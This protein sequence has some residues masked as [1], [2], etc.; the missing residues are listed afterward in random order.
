MRVRPAGLL[1]ALLMACAGDRGGER[2]TVTGNVVAGGM[3]GGASP[4]ALGGDA[5]PDARDADDDGDTIP[6]HVELGPN[7]AAPVDTDADGVADYL[8][9]DSD[10]DGVPD[11]AAGGVKD[12]DGDGILDHLDP[13]SDGDGIA[14]TLELG[15]TPGMPR[16]TDLDGAPDYLDADSDS[17]GLHDG[18]EDR[19]GNGLLEAAE[20]DPF[21]ADTD[22]DGASDLVEA[23]ARTDAR[24]PEVNPQSQGNFVFVVPHQQPPSPSDS[25][26]DFAT[27]LVR[28]D[29]MFSFDT[30][31]S[32]IE[33]L[34]QLRSDLR[35]KIIPALS[36]EIPDLAFGVASYED[37]PIPRKFGDLG[38]LPVRLVTPITTD[39]A[40]AQAGIDRLMIMSGGDGPE[41]G[42]EALYQLATGAGVSWPGGQVAPFKTGWRDGALPIL[43]Q[44][45]DAGM[46][47]AETYGAAVPNAASLPEM[48]V[49]LDAMGAKVIAVVSLG[50]DIAAANA[51]YLPLVRATGAT[52][53]PDA[54]GSSG[55]CETGVG[56]SP[57]EPDADGRCPLL[58]GI[59]ELGAG[60]GT[61]I[62]DAVGALANYAVFDIDAR[63][64]NEPGNVDAQGNEVDAI[65][66]FLDRVEA[67]ANPAASTTCVQGLATQDR[68]AMDSRLDTFVDVAPGQRVCFDVIAKQNQQIEAQPY[69]QLFRARID[70]SGDGVTALDS[71]QV[72]FLV[73][74]TPPRPGDKPII[75]L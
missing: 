75:V 26:L 37:F 56:G 61:S 20:S 28:A 47:S 43:V 33:E 60:L 27:D 21:T 7:P 50:G 23:A 41:S 31:G 9:L 69:P 35:G 49:A 38:D 48:Q 73:P 17:D 44:I 36:A 18:L 30:T 1:L 19:N 55:T 53:P 62:V 10:G 16:D 54:F 13:D 51:Q 11:R 59:D 4:S 57:V 3:A 58:F 70:L 2:Q 32:M 45:T 67:N 66:A 22:G 68:L 63:A 42:A 71:R 65:D 6:D 14:D 24:D 40:A 8:D 52:V 64:A 39:A 5:V 74:P 34:E 15:A 25:T 29:V 72:W 12:T 46:N